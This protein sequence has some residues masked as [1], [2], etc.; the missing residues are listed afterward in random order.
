MSAPA[1]STLAETDLYAP[2]RDYLADQGYAVQGEVK[3]CD[4]AAARDG[5][6][7]VVEMKLRLSAEALAQAAQRQEIAD[8]VYLAIPRPK[9]LTAWRRRSGHWLYLIRRMELGLLLVS[10]RARKASRVAVE[11]PVQI[12]DPVKQGGRRGAV[13]REVRRRAGDF[14]EGGS[15]R[16]KLLNSYRQTAIHVAC[17]LERCGPL[18]IRQLHRLGTGL[19]TRSALENS[20]RIEKWF[21]LEPPST[22]A[23]TDEGRAG[24]AEFAEAAE[25]YREL[26]RDRE[27]DR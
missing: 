20:L 7:L 19:D 11:Q 22:Y 27:L 1:T 9:A 23:L 2:I 25:H 21:R 15:V 13:V 5:R 3:K 10:P 17:C 12:W 14:N 18:T 4:I 24:L 8:E 16:R 26:L 6:L